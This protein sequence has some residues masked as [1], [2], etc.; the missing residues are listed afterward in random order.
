LADVSFLVTNWSCGWTTWNITGTRVVLAAWLAHISVTN[1]RA[2]FALSLLCHSNLTNSGEAIITV[3]I[4]LTF[5]GDWFTGVGVCIAEVGNIAI[6]VILATTCVAIL[7]T[8]RLGVGTVK[9]IIVASWT[10]PI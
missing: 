2:I 10:A 5:I 7:V 1:M 9:V 4:C 6:I 8:D 3:G